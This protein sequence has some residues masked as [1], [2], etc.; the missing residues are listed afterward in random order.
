VA[1]C[2]RPGLGGGG[3]GGES[4]GRCPLFRR[5]QP[6]AC[7]GAAGEQGGA[8]KSGG[9]PSPGAGGGADGPRSGPSCALPTFLEG[10]ARPG[11]Q[12]CTSSCPALIRSAPGSSE[13]RTGGAS[14]RLAPPRGGGEGGKEGGASRHCAPPNP[15]E[16]T[17]PAAAAGKAVFYWVFP[18]LEEGYPCFAL[19]ELPA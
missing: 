17:P 13:P 11:R 10:N 12:M 6:G 14:A 19:G 3:G 9:R 2:Q 7:P 4:Q 16:A 8:G 1:R 18:G 15:S 5:A